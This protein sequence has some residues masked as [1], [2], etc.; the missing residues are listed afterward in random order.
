MENTKSKL[1]ANLQPDNFF[2]SKILKDCLTLNE[3]KS[4]IIH[5]LDKF[6]CIQAQQIRGSETQYY[7]GFIY[8]YTPAIIDKY[9]KAAENLAFKM[10][11][12]ILTKNTFNYLTTK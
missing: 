8:G 5:Y 10:E 3:L 2:E 6:K 11:Y 7:N 12:K 1:Y 9:I 4:N